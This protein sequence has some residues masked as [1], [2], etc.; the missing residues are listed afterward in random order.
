MK[1]LLISLLLAAST[2]AFAG[3]TTAGQ[4][5]NI[6]FMP[7]GVILFDVNAPHSSP[8]SCV[9]QTIRWAINSITPAGKS[10]VVGI[11]TA[12]ATGKDVTM[13]GT[14]SCDLWG[15]TESVH[16]FIINN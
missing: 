11:L 15:D 16:Y 5:K 4:I 10:Q 7:N 8:P 12:Y 2:S 6:I 1:N 13:V 14:H 3:G 9:T